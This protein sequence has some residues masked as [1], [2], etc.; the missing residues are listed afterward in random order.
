MSTKVKENKVCF[1]P[2]ISQYKCFW[3]IS[4]L[5]FFLSMWFLNWITLRNPSLKQWMSGFWTLQKDHKFPFCLKHKLPILQIIIKTKGS[6]SLMKN[7]LI[8][9]LFLYMLMFLISLFVLSSSC[10]LFSLPRCFLE[11]LLPLSPQRK[12]SSCM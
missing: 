7:I 3:W 5:I 6:S 9:E 12:C 2:H 11:L 4:R 1:L 10:P 8:S